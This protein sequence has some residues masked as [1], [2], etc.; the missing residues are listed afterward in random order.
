MGNELGGGVVQVK[1]ADVDERLKY[2]L[3]KLKEIEIQLQKLEAVELKSMGQSG[4]QDDIKN[5]LDEL[6]A[7][8][9]L[10]VAE[11]NDIDA[12]VRRIVVEKSK[13]LPSYKDGDKIV[14]SAYW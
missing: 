8:G 9:V 12:K 14:E 3:V 2:Q 5:R 1:N 10:S 13:S 4:L 11:R 7:M 6:Q